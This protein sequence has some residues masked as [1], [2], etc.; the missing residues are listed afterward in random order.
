M[1]HIKF[2]ARPQTPVVSPRFAPRA[3]DDDHRESSA[4]KSKAS[5]DDEQVVVSTEAAS[6]QGGGSDGDNPS[7]SS[8][9]SENA[10]DSGGRLKV[11]AEAALASVSYDFR[12]STVMRA[13]VM[14][15]E[16]FT[17]YFLKGFARPSGAESIPDPRENEAVVFNDFFAAGLH[18]TPDSFGYSSQ[19]LGAVASVDAECHHSEQ[20]V[21]LGCYFL[22]ASTYCR[23]FCSSVRA[24]LSE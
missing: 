11:G 16:S 14:T 24:T 18:F 8:N 23:Q 17:R 22:R 4:E 7:D 1:V 19:I 9:G 2:T 21:C 15:L 5:V 12:Q 20:Q 10:Y 3:S 13:R 6:E